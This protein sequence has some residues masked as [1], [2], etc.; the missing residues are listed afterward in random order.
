MSLIFSSNRMGVGGNVN[1]FSKEFFP[2]PFWVSGHDNIYLIKAKK[3]KIISQT[4]KNI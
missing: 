2:A 4:S 1:N 3:T